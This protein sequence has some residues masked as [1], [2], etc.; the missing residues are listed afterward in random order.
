[1][2]KKDD[3]SS[4]SL[5]REI[6]VHPW[7]LPRVSILGPGLIPLEHMP[8]R[9]RSAADGFGTSRRKFFQSKFVELQSFE[10]MISSH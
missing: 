6:R 8:G 3:F 5:I 9:S 4:F 2:Q 1:M 10:S 7:L